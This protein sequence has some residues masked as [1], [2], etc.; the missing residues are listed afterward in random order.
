MYN[1]GAWLGSAVSNN[2]VNN[3]LLF[4]LFFQFC[5]GTNVLGH[6]PSAESA[7]AGLDPGVGVERGQPVHLRVQQPPVPDGVPAA[8]VPL[9][10]VGGRRRRRQPPRRVQPL[11]LVG[12][13]LPHRHAPLLGPRRQS[14]NRPSPHHHQHQHRRRRRRRRRRDAGDTR[15]RRR[16]TGAARRPVGVQRLTTPLDGVA[17]ALNPS[18]NET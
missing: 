7:R 9:A 3:K 4:V 11:A 18:Y 10:G 1:A 12:P 14:E 17:S 6:D 15:R 2:K 16:R 8:A 13:H 5:N